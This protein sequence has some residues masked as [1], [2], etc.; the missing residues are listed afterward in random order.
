MTTRPLVRTGLE[1]L[2]DE[3]FAPLRG[4]RVGLVTHPAAVAADLRH[5]ANVLADASVV[6]LAALFGPEHG[7]LGEAQDLVAIPAGGAPAGP[8]VHSLYGK[9]AD[10]LRP[11]AEQLR[12]LDALV[13]DLQ[14]VGSRYY[15]FQATMLY[16]L[17]AA[18]RHGLLAVVL[19]RPNPLGGE[20]VEGPALR[21][22]YESFVGPHRIATRHGLTMGELAR[23]YQKE[24]G[25]GGE[26]L[27]IPCAGWRRDMDFEAT[28]LP[29]VLPSPNMPTVETAFVYPGQCLLEGTNLSE[30]RGTTRPFELCGAPWIDASA[31]AGQLRTQGLPG[32][33]FRPAWFRP[34]FHKF[35]GQDCGG[36]QLHVTDRQVFRPVR[37]GLAVLAALRELSGPRFAWRTE[38]YEF[39]T[40]RLAIDLLF[41]SPRERLAL[42]ADREAD[43]TAR[44]WEAA[45]EDFRRRRQASLLYS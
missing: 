38:P 19:D 32:V 23:L 45:E 28:G 4:L 31:L 21:P 35:A 34:T 39:V 37:T 36:V 30:G 26:L 43:E 29:W 27:V 12:G 8:R 11:T 41:G 1:V 25:L 6:H 33:A 18:A 17:E 16:C 40:D 20:A 22:G 13:I 9:T 7:L 15:T 3:G 5:A 42:D 2:R 14:D 10:S 24:R 44:A